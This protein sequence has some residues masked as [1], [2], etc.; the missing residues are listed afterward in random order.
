VWSWSVSLVVCLGGIY[1][2]WPSKVDIL[3]D[4]LIDDASHHT[5]TSIPRAFIDTLIADNLERHLA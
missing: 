1:R 5:G 3:L 2:W 4:T